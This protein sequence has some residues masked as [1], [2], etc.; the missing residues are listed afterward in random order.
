MKGGAALALAGLVFLAMGLKGTYKDVYNALLGKG[1]PAAIP[2]TYT[3]PTT[4]PVFKCIMIAA[5]GSTIIDADSTGKCPPGSYPTGGG[6]LPATPGFTPTG[7]N[8]GGSGFGR[9]PAYYDGPAWYH[10]PFRQNGNV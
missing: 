3:P 7:A 8:G 10:G 2:G 1:P 6:G 9:M 5:N 4:L